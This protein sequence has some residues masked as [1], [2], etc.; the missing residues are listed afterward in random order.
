MG[1]SVWSD[2]AKFSSAPSAQFGAI[3]HGIFGVADCNKPPLPVFS[4]PFV[5]LHIAFLPLQIQ[6]RLEAPSLQQ[7]LQLAVNAFLGWPK[8]FP[9]KFQ[10]HRGGISPPL[11]WNPAPAPP[12]CNRKV[13]NG[14]TKFHTRKQIWGHFSCADLWGPLGSHG[15]LAPV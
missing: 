14:K 10:A 3:I 5:G 7:V 9:P 11:K 12:G 2:W 4:S 1:G 6:K 13:L 8:I 15:P